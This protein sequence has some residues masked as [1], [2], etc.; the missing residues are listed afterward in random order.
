M[1]A[2]GLVGTATKMM[3]A[4]NSSNEGQINSTLYAGGLLGKCGTAFYASESSNKADITSVQAAGGLVGSVDYYAVI[5]LCY[6]TGN[7]TS[8]TDNTFLGAGGLIGCCYSTGGEALPSVEISE[9]YNRGNISAPCAGGL[10]GVT[11]EIKLTNVY[12]AGSVSG[13]K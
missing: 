7:I 9:S 12:N 5:T 13:N 1:Y 6:N 11:Y 10:L 2:G 4:L 8:T 3:Y